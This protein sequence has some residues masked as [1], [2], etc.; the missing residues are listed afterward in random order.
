M[1]LKDMEGFKEFWDEQKPIMDLEEKGSSG[2][3]IEGDS[4]E[5]ADKLAREKMKKDKNL[6][7]EDAISLVFEEHPEFNEEYEPKKIRK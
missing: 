3:G 1:A 6:S 4:T 2:D 5:K 7:Y